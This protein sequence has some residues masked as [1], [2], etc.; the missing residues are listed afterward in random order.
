MATKKKTTT[1]NSDEPESVVEGEGTSEII[2]DIIP[3]PIPDE[4]QESTTA[5]QLEPPQPR[6]RR[7]QLKE[8]KK[9]FR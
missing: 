6:F 3:E 2:Q 7:G 5:I 9:V 8:V 1:T 4:P